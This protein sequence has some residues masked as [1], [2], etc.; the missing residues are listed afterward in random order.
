MNDPEVTVIIE[1]KDQGQSIVYEDDKGDNSQMLK[2][3]NLFNDVDEQ[4]EEEVKRPRAAV[5]PQPSK[6]SAM[7]VAHNN[8]SNNN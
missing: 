7:A 6:S 5:A 8:D 3:L 2:D 4:E 1:N